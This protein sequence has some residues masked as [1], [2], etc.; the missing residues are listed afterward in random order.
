MELEQEEFS[1][2]LTSLATTIGGFASYDNLEKYA[3][4]ADN[5]DNVNLRLAE[6]VDKAR[7]YNQ[8]EFLV[9]KE[10]KD[11]SEL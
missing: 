10:L 5:V 11:Y 4:I 1:E 3:D 6:C 7:L 8:R 9:G 2:Q